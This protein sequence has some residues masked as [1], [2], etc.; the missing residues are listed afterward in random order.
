[1]KTIKNYYKAGLLAVLFGI[2][3]CKKLDLAP[4]DRFT[5]VNFWTTNDRFKYGIFSDVP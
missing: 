4:T 2:S 5:D 3:A 1:M